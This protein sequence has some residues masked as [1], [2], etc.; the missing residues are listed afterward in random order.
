M[1]TVLLRKN[2]S[3]RQDDDDV[4]HSYDRLGED[5]VEKFQLKLARALVVFME[6]LHLL[7]ARN[8]DLLLDV[9]KNRKKFGI[10][11]HPRDIP[12][13][14]MHKVSSR[15]DL[16]LSAMNRTPSRSRSRRGGEHPK[17]LSFPVAESMSSREDSSVK[18]K[19]SS[20]EY[21]PGTMGSSKDSVNERGN[22]RADPAQ[23]TDSAIGIQR[24]LQLAF[25]NIAKD[26]YPMIHGI[27][28]ND[29]PRWLKDCCQDSYFSKYTYRRA[30]IRKLSIV[31]FSGSCIS[32]CVR[33]QFF[34]MALNSRPMEPSVVLLCVALLAIGEELI[35][36]DANTSSLDGKD[37]DAM[38]LSKSYHA[39][40][41]GSM[42]S[43]YR[44]DKSY[45]SQVAPD[46]PG[47]S[48]GS[49][50]NV[51]RGSE[52]GRS[53]KSLMSIRSQKDRSI[54]S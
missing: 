22:A 38:I 33:R 29:T 23:R 18:T 26:V 6:L 45:T 37:N 16:S 20:E 12:N 28:E 4:L 36:E 49:S 32:V 30:K 10:S 39:E 11:K 43:Y 47:G 1:G 50:S 7:I 5:E 24:E 17:R 42:S 27:M 53:T 13:S 54:P 3:V 8:R 25:I 14:S 51:S 19:S 34:W 46:S 44:S 40:R 35:F 9:V 41:T 2:T 31:V 15:G 52:A 48:I 21:D